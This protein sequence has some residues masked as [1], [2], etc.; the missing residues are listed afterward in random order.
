MAD[1]Q[2]VHCLCVHF[3]LFA[4]GRRAQTK[5]LIEYVSKEISPDAPLIIAGDFN[6]WRNQMSRTLSP[7]KRAACTQFSCWFTDV[8]SGS[9]LRSRLQRSS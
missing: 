4:N 6:D 8:S 7:A 2:R 5:A 1:Q 9:N 3:G